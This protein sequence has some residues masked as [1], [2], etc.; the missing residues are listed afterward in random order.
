MGTWR[1]C[2]RSTC[3]RRH[4]SDERKD[5]GDRGQRLSITAE[6]APAETEEQEDYCDCGGVEAWQQR[7]DV[8]CPVDFLPLQFTQTE[9]RRGEGSS[10]QE[11]PCTPTSFG[12]VPLV[13]D[14]MQ[15][16]VCGFL[17]SEQQKTVITNQAPFVTKALCQI[18]KSVWRPAIEQAKCSECNWCASCNTKKKH[19]LGVLWTTRARSA[20]PET[21][22][23][24]RTRALRQ[25]SLRKTRN[26]PR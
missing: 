25:A 2:R 12:D 19:A 1:G 17:L 7:H 20:D 8:L 5:G 4:L 15:P 9:L 23:R 3:G 10:E 13:L 26:T 24:A 14:W 22:A 21:V 18:E 6:L 16:L 11:K